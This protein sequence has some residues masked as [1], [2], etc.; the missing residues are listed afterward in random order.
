MKCPTNKYI[1]PPKGFTQDN[2]WYNISSCENI[3]TICNWHCTLEKYP[4]DPIG[5]VFGLLTGKYWDVIVKCSWPV[6]RSQ[7]LLRKK[8]LVSSITLHS[9]WSC[10]QKAQR[11]VICKEE[12]VYGEKGSY[13]LC[14]GH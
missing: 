9:P 7:A 14:I 10:L 13:P 2:F 1:Q 6:K 5:H 11:S 4:T 8:F 3:R 12:E